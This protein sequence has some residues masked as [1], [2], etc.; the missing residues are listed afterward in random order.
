MK[1][2]QIGTFRGI[3][4]KLHW[5][6]V[7]LAILLTLVVATG[8][9]PQLTP[10]LS[11]EAYLLGGF[12]A[13]AALLLSILVHEAAHAL[14]AQRYGVEVSSITLWLLGGVA[15]LEEEAP[16]PRAESRIA[17]AGPA[18][19]LAIAA[20]ALSLGGL[21]ALSK[22]SPLL[23]AV[24]LWIG[25]LNVVLAVFNLLPGAP[26][27]GG[28][29]LHAWLWKRYGDRTRATVGAAKAGRVVG[30]VVAA[31]GAVE[32]LAGNIGGLWTSLIGWFLFAAAGQEAKVGRL[33]G[34][35][36]ERKLSDIMAPLPPSI[37]NW[38]PLRDVLAT[39][40]GAEPIVAVDFGGS[41]TAVVSQRDVVRAA[42]R[43]AERNAMPERLRE[44]PLPEPV[45]LGVDDPASTILR[46]PGLPIIVLDDEKPVGVV[47]STE[48]DRAI[49]M[50]Y[51][52]AD[53]QRA[54]A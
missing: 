15:H 12:L 17:G 9:L 30:V 33:S 13:G 11:D 3:P 10:G 49:A 2:R 38:T 47:T 44:L 27:D 52:A 43:A 8:V 25:G 23:S 29:L 20:I 7:V 32:F 46:H 19:S 24:L 39:G 16:S 50:H 37:A 40:G 42:A 53:E 6:A 18:S 54:A 21:V 28:R 34:V 5:G 36:R 1:A 31:I 51:M 35:L 48:I 4:V 26:L 41:V 22:V 45:T 14:V